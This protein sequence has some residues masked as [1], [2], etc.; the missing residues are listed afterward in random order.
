MFKDNFENSEKIYEKMYKAY[1]SKDSYLLNDIEEKNRG[2]GKSYNI[3]KLAIKENLPIFCGCQ[4]TKRYLED[5]AKKEF[6]KEVEVVSFI[7]TE[8]FRGHK[9]PEVIL[10]E[11]LP[12]SIIFDEF[13]DKGIIVIGTHRG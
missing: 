3:V 4:S 12:L 10:T 13:V 8:A 1:L 5:L 2:I 11:G 7:S 9:I 6:N